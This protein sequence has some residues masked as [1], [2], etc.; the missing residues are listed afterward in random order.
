ML[1][2]FYEWL[3]GKLYAYYGYSLTVKYQE[4]N[5]ARIRRLP[6]IAS[7]ECLRYHGEDLSSNVIM[8]GRPIGPTNI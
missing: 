7:N 6:I 3:G 2:K 1:T 5:L 4:A 8:L